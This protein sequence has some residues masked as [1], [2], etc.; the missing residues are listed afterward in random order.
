MKK[1]K[2]IFIIV[3][4]IFLSAE[5]VVNIFLNINQKNFLNRAI[6]GFKIAGI[7]YLLPNLG[8]LFGTKY[9]SD[10]VDINTD[11]IF[12]TLKLDKLFKKEILIKTLY[13]KGVNIDIKTFKPVEGETV[14]HE[15]PQ[16]LFIYFP[17]EVN[18]KNIKINFNGEIITINNLS[19]RNLSSDKICLFAT[20]KWK[21][22]RFNVDIIND[23]QKSKFFTKG[24]IFFPV[25]RLITNY[26]LDLE[27]SGNYNLEQFKNFKLS[28]ISSKKMYTLYGKIKLSPLEAY[29]NIET[30]IL[31][32]KISFTKEDD[33]I[34][35]TYDGNLTLRE[36]A[37][38]RLGIDVPGD[39]IT[40]FVY[41]K[42]A[43]M[44]T[45]LGEIKNKKLGL[46]LTVHNNKGD[47]K[48]KLDK[49]HISGRIFYDTT[50]KSLVLKDNYD[51]KIID[52]LLALHGKNEFSSKG[53]LFGY[54]FLC[55]SK[56]QET[57]FID[58]S[59]SKTN[60][61]Q[62]KFNFVS[63]FSLTT[64]QLYYEN[65]PKNIN[66]V[67]KLLYDIDNQINLTASCKNFNILGNKLS[68]DMSAKATQ[69]KDL[70]QK[71]LY[72]ITI[73]LNNVNFNKY[74]VLNEL[75]LTG[76]YHDDV[77]RI[78][79][80]SADKS[81]NLDGNCDLRNNI[82]NL[83]I[84]VHKKNLLLEKLAVKD[85]IARISINKHKKFDLHCDYSLYGLAYNK[86]NIL[87]S[88]S[89]KIL[90]D[91][92]KNCLVS[93]GQV[94]FTSQVKSE[95]KTNLIVDKNKVYLELYK[96]T[97]PGVLKTFQA[98]LWF[99]FAKKS[100]ATVS[101]R[102]Y[103]ASSE[104]IISSGTVFLDKNNATLV[105]RIK[106]LSVKNINIISDLYVEAD[107]HDKKKLEVKTMF[108]NLWVNN[109]LVDKLNTKCVVYLDKN[110][111]SFSP[112]ADN[113]SEA[114]FSGDIIINKT[115]FEF[116][117]FRIVLS[118]NKQLL[119]DG[120]IGTK[121]DLLTIR[122]VHFPIEVASAIFN[123]SIPV[124]S[125]D[126][127]VDCT[128]ITLDQEKRMYQINCGF[129]IENLEIA[130][131]KVK[132]VTGRV[133][134][135]KDY[136]NFE[137]ISFIFKPNNV[138]I[139]N[140][141]YN[142]KNKNLDIALLSQKCDLS[143][144]DGFM[145]I[146]KTAQGNFVVDIKIKGKPSEPKL[147]GYIFLPKGR[148][149][150]DRYA[151]YLNNI[152]LKLNFTGEKIKLEKC[153]A[154]YE[155][156]KLVLDGSYDISKD[157]YFVSIKTTG[158][159]GIFMNIPELSY[160]PSDVLRIIKS[161]KGFTSNGNLHFDLKVQKDI[162][163][164]LPTVTGNIVMNNTYFTYPGTEGKKIANVDAFYYDITLA[165]NN[166]VWYENE[167]LSANIVGKVHFKYTSGMKK[168]DVNGEMQ[169]LRGKVKFLNTQLNIRSGEVEIIKRDVYITLE[170]ETEIFTTENEKIPVRLV[171]ARAKVENIQPKLYT[172]MYPQLTTEELTSLMIGT[173]KLQKYGDKVEIY[174]SE[175]IDYL[176]YLRTQFLKIIDTTLA[177]PISRN[178][179]QKWGIADKLVI[180]QAEPSSTTQKVQQETSLSGTSGIDAVDI[181]KDTKYGIEKYLTP[182]MAISYSVT[183]AEIKDKLNLKHEF[184]ISYR[185]KNNIFIKGIY[186]YAIRD[187]NTGRY[188][189]DVKIQIEP[190]FKLKSW[191]EEEKEQQKTK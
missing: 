185:L 70:L 154:E 128:I 148:I 82:L 53:I 152:N 10:I 99:D 52:F 69:N 111:L 11:V 109:Y 159:D 79:G 37:K 49:K 55:Q 91:F 145:D 44:L 172:P 187:Y 147:Y 22:Y 120:R 117:Q 5:V 177:E 16:E 14:K 186:D 155:Q 176:P 23:I 163:D 77:I 190:R 42:K 103:D 92:S 184:E 191:S 113:I 153:T 7:V 180:T 30:E 17:L 88:A 121:N 2:L 61:E 73:L 4:V 35:V 161:Q 72:T 27:L 64:V 86:L 124:T 101:G 116:K 158:G 104:I 97:L 171:I 162:K 75:L 38:K 115:K 166:N 135:Y 108:K 130:T 18:I 131:L 125:G 57:K 8:L 46:N 12:L 112:V 67:T 110:I 138:I 181:V 90:Y 168:S 62:V 156:T 40:K 31:Q 129:N 106:N 50:Q 28:L 188:S 146:V 160:Y 83:L 164:E 3:V 39:F 127:N 9:T 183:L 167:S 173:G 87:E 98:E 95:Y 132:N 137:R 32:G 26:Y 60:I 114:Y 150:F 81:I 6:P 102:I 100:F 45:I 56:F 94:G 165:A 143:I 71:Q 133:S 85:V 142:T 107:F 13:S 189:G 144:F 170:A 182:D 126:T 47:F 78:S 41:T 33:I 80:E 96:L 48:L 178:I 36:E 43:D 29:G 1:I 51:G 25:A 74:K 105:T 179:L 141:A 68:F 66:L 139:L 24:K 59:F 34:N 175:R 140:G 149:T 118:Q 123:I 93:H 65:F 174:A 157:K 58:I 21:V 169:A 20:G 15:L 136:I 54:T 151:K 134:T 19:G 119:F 76:T 89:G 122:L 63:T 84:S